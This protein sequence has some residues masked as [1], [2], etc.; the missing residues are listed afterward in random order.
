MLDL[1]RLLLCDTGPQH[2]SQR[3]GAKRNSLSKLTSFNSAI[4]TQE[5]PRGAEWCL[6]QLLRTLYQPK[7][8]AK[9][10]MQRFGVVANDIETATFCWAFWSKRTHDHMATRS[11][12]AGDLPNV[13]DTLFRCREEMKYS[14]VTPRTR[15][16][17]RDRQAF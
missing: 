13:C 12:R 9:L 3:S 1:L 7:P 17:L 16:L 6:V 10:P 15:G 14:A 2:P 8:S 5:L 4:A 11:N